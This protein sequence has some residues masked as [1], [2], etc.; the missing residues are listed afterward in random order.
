MDCNFLNSQHIIL[1]QYPFQFTIN[2]KEDDKLEFA[3]FSELIE[4]NFQDN[5]PAVFALI[6]NRTEN[7]FAK[8]NLHYFFATR[9][10]TKWVDD[11]FI[12]PS[13]K[14]KIEMIHYFAIMPN[15]EK[16]QNSK[17]LHFEYLGALRDS[18]EFLNQQA[19]ETKKKI[20]RFLE[21]SF[22]NF[23]VL[24]ELKYEIENNTKQ[25]LEDS[26]KASIYLETYFSPVK[27]KL[28][29]DVSTIEAVDKSS[30]L[31]K[32]VN[33][34]Q[35]V[36]PIFLAISKPDLKEQILLLDATTFVRINEK[37]ASLRLPDEKKVHQKMKE[38]FGYCMLKEDG[39]EL[40]RENAYQ[41][42]L[43]FLD[44]FDKASKLD[45][46]AILSL[47]KSFE[48][49]TLIL[50]K[51]L[52]LSFQ[53]YQKAVNH[54][55]ERI[56][57]LEIIAEENCDTV[58]K[59]P[60]YKKLEKELSDLKPKIIDLVL[61]SKECQRLFFR[62]RQE[63]NHENQ[64][65]MFEAQYLKL[66][67]NLKSGND[68][69]G[70]LEIGVSC[71]DQ[72][73]YFDL[74]DNHL[75]NNEI[76]KAQKLY[77]TLIFSSHIPRSPRS[78]EFFSKIKK[79]VKDRKEWIF[80]LAARNDLLA[81]LDATEIYLDENNLEKAKN[82]FQIYSNFSN[83]EN[84]SSRV[85]SIYQ[86]I[87]K[88]IKN[89][90]EY[91]DFVKKLSDDYFYPATLDLA[92]CFI[93]GKGIKRCLENA[94]HLIS[95][96]NSELQQ[97]FES[98]IILAR[99][100]IVDEQYEAA[101]KHL[102]HLKPLKNQ[103][104]CFDYLMSIIN[105]RLIGFLESP[106]KDQLDQIQTIEKNLQNPPEEFRSEYKY[107]LGLF[108]LYQS[109]IEL[110]IKNLHESSKNGSHLADYKLG[111]IYHELPK[112]RNLEL[113]V[114]YF[115]KSSRRGN[116]NACF[117]LGYF[118]ERGYG[119]KVND[120]LAFEHYLKAANMG[121]FGAMYRVGAYYEKGSPVEIN[122]VKALDYY[123]IAAF[124]KNPFSQ[125]KYG[126]MINDDDHS[127]YWYEEAFQNFIV[128]SD[129]GNY[130]ATIELAKCYN[131]V[132][133][134]K[135]SIH[136]FKE[137]LHLAKMQLLSAIKNGDL[138]AEYELG[139]FYEEGLGEDRE[140][141]IASKYYLSAAEK[142]HVIAQYKVGMDNI[143]NF[144]VDKA[145]DW[146]KKAHERGYVDATFQLAIIYNSE[147]YGVKD[148]SLAF[149]YFEE[150]S[151]LQHASSYYEL[152]KFYLNNNSFID[153]NH[154]KAHELLLKALKRGHPIAYYKYA[155][156]AE[157]G[158]IKGVSE[159]EIQ[160]FYTNAFELLSKN[161]DSQP[162]SYSYYL[163]LCYERGLGVEKSIKLALK[164]Y[165]KAAERGHKKA[166]YAM[167][168]YY[169][170]NALKGDV[171]AELQLARIYEE[172]FRD[173]NPDYTKAIRIYE[174]HLH[175][176]HSFAMYRLGLAYLE[177]RGVAEN[178]KKAFCFFKILASNQYAEAYY[179]LG[180][181][182]A[183]GLGVD[184]D[185]DLA[186]INLQKALKFDASK[187]SYLLSKL[188]T[189]KQGQPLSG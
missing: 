156:F 143:Q 89:D 136:V 145:I 138:E 17:E 182:Y 81:V 23:E 26:R 96:L 146:F 18:K 54:L 13:T 160:N 131:Y 92:V 105:Y 62:W 48:T 77:E 115:Q 177:G 108:Y 128:E 119:V 85:K 110:A 141:E 57:K 117:K 102:I 83:D 99:I 164:F 189:L 166:Y 90:I 165:K 11:H 19:F 134:T 153:Q 7:Q 129:R 29:F 154:K 58:K 150:A 47:A 31:Q 87:K 181:C 144:H 56:K 183:Y 127:K 111:V 60:E 93:E 106:S 135:K 167:I 33:E 20:Y 174:K 100:D 124:G 6:Q 88:K 151:K 61:K 130:K 188:E 149:S 5:K 80:D 74:I 3:P 180:L 65:K 10:F 113:A 8:V 15:F 2:A 101:K 139:L 1:N 148:P 94:K 137:H 109:N 51:H 25:L 116:E 14:E 97:S 91:F 175:S 68:Y 118:Y 187:A 147:Y 82:N 162:S 103:Q 52:E 76:D 173:I 46:N 95:N 107:H 24:E 32:S 67:N 125:M 55:F 73:A 123:K 43:Q 159:A 84:D 12:N 39:Y 72:T 78:N 28:F 169:E 79:Q 45:L 170:K 71:S 114:A 66:K 35:Q 27:T 44:L 140:D 168:A 50:P 21:A 186:K 40:I 112:Y 176:D 120:V 155:L 69:Q 161:L 53:W 152:S 59:Q 38:I 49:G 30:A 41:K 70:F 104:K 63:V 126:E 178:F 16:F 34:I 133:G 122:Q 98:K 75:L 158:L 163:G 9:T 121:H 64:I 37:K 42:V 4:E 36:L 22:G 171:N 157:Q 132:T 184:Q 185:L 142:G 86:K 179:Y 172:K